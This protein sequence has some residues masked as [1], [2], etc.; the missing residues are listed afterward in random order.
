MRRRE[1]I[2]LVGGVALCRAGAAH[3]VG[4]RIE[5]GMCS[6]IRETPASVLTVLALA[7]EVIDWL[8]VKLMRIKR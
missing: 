8:L 3:C 7:D 1:F 5:Y 6:A 2:G 4:D